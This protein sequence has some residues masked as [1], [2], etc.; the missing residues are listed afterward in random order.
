[1]IIEHIVRIR[2]PEGEREVNLKDLSEEKRKE[3]TNALNIKMLSRLN[4]IPE[5]TA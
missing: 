2:G 4:Y 1:M 5:K 3:I